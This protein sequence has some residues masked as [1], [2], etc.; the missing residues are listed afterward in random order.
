MIIN[1]IWWPRPS[2]EVVAFWLPAELYQP[3]GAYFILVMSAFHNLMGH[4]FFKERLVWLSSF[5]SQ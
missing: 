5:F 4:F 3:S 2:A 1:S